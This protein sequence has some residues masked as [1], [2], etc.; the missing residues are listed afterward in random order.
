MS[1]RESWGTRFQ[2]SKSGVVTS[3]RSVRESIG[4]ALLP[5]TVRD[6][7]HSRW[8]RAESSAAKAKCEN[9]VER[10]CVTSSLATWLVYV[11]ASFQR[12]SSRKI[13]S[14]LR[15]I[16]AWRIVCLYSAYTHLV[17]SRD[18]QYRCTLDRSSA[19]ASTGRSCRSTRT[20]STGAIFRRLITPR[21]TC[22]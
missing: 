12:L 11:F 13:A 2:A 19:T 16:Y 20:S 4:A 5:T 8:N 7:I 3:A 9:K 1:M 15:T 22:Y 21:R 18:R 17:I 10:M 6:S 14:F